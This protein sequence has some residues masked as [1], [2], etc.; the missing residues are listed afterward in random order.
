VTLIS[1]VNNNDEFIRPTPSTLL[2][3][4]ANNIE[5]GGQQY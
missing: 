2:N 5:R 3:G 1:S 4:L